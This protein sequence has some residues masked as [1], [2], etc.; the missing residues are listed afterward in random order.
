MKPRR[1]HHRLERLL[2]SWHPSTAALSAWSLSSCAVQARAQRRREGK[3][4]WKLS[5]THRS[6]VSPSNDASW[7]SSSWQVRGTATCFPS[8]L[9]AESIGI[10]PQ[11]LRCHPRRNSRRGSD[12]LLAL[13]HRVGHPRCPRPR[14]A[15]PR[16]QFERLLLEAAGHTRPRGP[17]PRRRVERDSWTPCFLPS[18]GFRRGA[19]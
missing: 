3:R 13:S 14:S 7:R 2:S 15:R 11:V 12:G 1:L 16:L 17:S 18:R 19:T 4:H 9:R 6:A 10:E 8:L 5:S